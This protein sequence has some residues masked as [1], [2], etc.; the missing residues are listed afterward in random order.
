MT[1]RIVDA[2]AISLT[3]REQQARERAETAVPEAYDAFLK[4][5]QHAQTRTPEQYAKALEYFQRAVELDPD[6]ARAH[7]AI[8]SVYW[9]SWWEGWYA[10]L[11][12]HTSGARDAAADRVGRAMAEPSALAH[13]V[14]AQMHL[15]GGRADDAIVEA[16]HAVDLNPNDAD[17]RAVLAEMLIYS[18][19]PEEALAAVAMARRL[20]PYNEARY[21]Y[22][23]GFARFGLEEFDAAAQ[24]LE[25]A[26]ELGSNL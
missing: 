22:L 6:Y 14:A 18:G 1:Q 4:G 5:W 8:A 12:V 15:W 20:D 24:L 3:A 26:L 23:E 9:K 7:A 13:Q 2:L 11:G 10:T 16:Q 25:R 17:S 21:A 19:R